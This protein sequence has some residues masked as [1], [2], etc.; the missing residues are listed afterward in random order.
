[1]T[2]SAASPLVGSTEENPR[3]RR[4]KQQVKIE[5]SAEKEASRT[6]MSNDTVDTALWS[7]GTGTQEVPT[8]GCMNWTAYTYASNETVIRFQ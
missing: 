1:M 8:G 7:A 6:K 4:Q 3:K 5:L 2:G